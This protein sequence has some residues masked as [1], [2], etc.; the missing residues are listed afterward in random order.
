MI[1]L[2]KFNPSQQF[3]D[4]QL[5]LIDGIDKNMFY[6]FLQEYTKD[7]GAVVIN[8]CVNSNKIK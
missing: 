1:T 3:K 2:R 8:M 6:E 7:H 4:S 5:I